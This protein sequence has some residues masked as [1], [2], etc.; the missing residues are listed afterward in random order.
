MHSVDEILL[1]TVT[2]LK[3][4]ALFLTFED[5]SQGLLHISEISDSYIRDIEKFGS[6][7]DQMKVKILSI[8]SANGFMRV[9]LKQVPEEE[10]FSTHSN[11][12]RKAPEVTNEDFKILEENLPKWIENTLANTKEKK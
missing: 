3:P 1:G 7:G 10:A 6:I 2:G 4:Y 11:N 8:D 12:R 5:G 9:S